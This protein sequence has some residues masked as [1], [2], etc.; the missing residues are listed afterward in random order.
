MAP[1]TSIIFI[2][3]S[4]PPPIMFYFLLTTKYFQ[5]IHLIC[6]SIVWQSVS[7]SCCRYHSLSHSPPQQNFWQLFFS[8]WKVWGY[9]TAL[10][11]W[12]I[13]FKISV[14]SSSWMKWIWRFWD[15]VTKLNCMKI[16]LGKNSSHKNFLP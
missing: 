14:S 10:I 3:L 13:N 16:T 8:F 4:H 5:I 2:F 6:S 1:M 11:S 15:K 7:S 9:L 12:F